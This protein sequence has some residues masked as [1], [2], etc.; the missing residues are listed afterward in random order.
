MAILVKAYD[1]TGG[2]R[3]LVKLAE[4]E[5]LG[6]AKLLLKALLEF[7]SVEEEGLVDAWAEDAS[8][9]ILATCAYDGK[10]EGYVE[11]AK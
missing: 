4:V 6:I 9:K 7:A 2:G 1:V 8:G 3:K 10:G 5:D 11:E